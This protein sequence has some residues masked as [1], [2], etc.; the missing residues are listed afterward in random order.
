MHPPSQ[1]VRKLFGFLVVVFFRREGKREAVCAQSGPDEEVER[2]YLVVANSVWTL[3]VGWAWLGADTTQ[4]MSKVPG[5][6]R[7][8]TPSHLGW[9]VEATAISTQTRQTSNLM[10]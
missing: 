2:M 9:H 1:R 7:A 5:L 10:N 4:L 3:D 6:P 8:W